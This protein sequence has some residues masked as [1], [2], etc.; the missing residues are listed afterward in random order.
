MI[1]RLKEFY[2]DNA[3]G[4]DQTIT[5]SKSVECNSGSADTFES[6]DGFSQIAP[7]NTET[8]ILF[9]ED[10]IYQVY[11]DDVFD[12]IAN[13]YL[14]L[15][16]SM[17]VFISASLCGNIGSN[18]IGVPQCAGDVPNYLN[19]AISKLILYISVS[20][21][22]YDTALN[23]AIQ[24][25]RCSTQTVSSQLYKQEAY[26]G[27][28]SPEDLLKIEISNIYLE[29]YK[30]DYVATAPADYAEIEAMYEY[31]KISYC[32]SK[33]GVMDCGVPA[34]PPGVAHTATISVVPT[35]IGLGVDTTVTVS[36]KFV[37]NDDIFIAVLDTN[38]PNVSVQKFDGFT[39]NEVIPNQ[40]TAKAYYISYSYERGGSTYQNTV[41]VNTTAYAPQWFGGES[42]VTDYDV[43]GK[44]DSALISASFSNIVP[45]Y[46]STSN[47]VTNNTNTDAKYIWWITTSPVKFYIGAFEIQTGPWDDACDPNSY[48]IIWKTLNTVMD[49]GI[50]EQV[51]YYYRTC[52]LQ[53][54]AGQ[55]LTYELKQ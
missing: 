45:V 52:P 20:N 24:K 30:V 40:T 5:L 13:Y 38:V 26:L 25:I 42:I 9:P 23:T 54:L 2:I 41:S 12:G 10:G 21:P 36:Y 11:I 1:E 27:T 14:T 29:L 19:N 7:A 15:F 55:T 35:V 50:T 49:D 48:A 37:A 32:I 22:V 28:S 16:N 44:G 34:P 17:I 47:K 31:D 8:K 4:L 3:T 51:L 18:C 53:D 6:V 33:L 39:Y 43:A 46:Q